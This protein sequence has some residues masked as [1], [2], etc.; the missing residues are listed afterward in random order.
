MPFSRSW[1]NTD[2]KRRVWSEIWPISVD[3]AVSWLTVCAARMTTLKTEVKGV[4]AAEQ[5]SDRLQQTRQRKKQA[6]ARY[7]T[8][9]LRLSGQLESINLLGTLA[10]PLVETAHGELKPLHDSGAI[11]LRH[12]QFVREL[13]E[14]GVCVCG[15]QL[16]MNSVH[17]HHVEERIAKTAD[18]ESRAEYLEQLYD[19]AHALVRK[20][21]TAD[22]RDRTGQLTQ[23]AVSL[24][25]EL[26]ELAREQREIDADLKMIDEDKIQM[27]RDEIGALQTQLDTVNRRIADNEMALP[28][29]CGADTFFEEAH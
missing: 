16:S 11:P 29:G 28:P 27:I 5:L 14:E 25:D 20:G 19:A 7:G 26:S 9:L 22:W 3:N 18:Q 15:Q 4:G 2:G 24:S 6:S 21:Q 10:G 17:R 23:D 12:L 13:L 1:R 8:A